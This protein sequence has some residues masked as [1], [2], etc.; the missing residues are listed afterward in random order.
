MKILFC[1]NNLSGL[2]SFR[3]P[4]IQYYRDK[5]C[6]VVLVVPKG[7][8][9][10]LSAVP[11]GVKCIQVDLDRTNTGLWNNVKLLFSLLK[12]Y[13][14]EKPDIIF[15]YTIKPNIFGTIASSIYSI[16]SIA[17]MAGLGV[18]FSKETLLYSIIRKVYKTALFGTKK[19]IV[20]NKANYDTLISLK[21]SNKDKLILV[22][23]E[24]VD[25]NYYHDT[26]NASDK[27]TFLFI[28]RILKEKGY[29]VFVDAAKRIK[30]K[31]PNVNFDIVG[32]FDKS[33]I[34]PITEEQVAKDENDG[35]INYRGCY[36]NMMDVYSQ[37][38]LVVT[39]PSYY[40]E[41]LNRSLMEACAC[42]KPVITTDVPG[43]KETVN[44]GVNGFLCEPNDVDSIVLAMEKYINLSDESKQQMSRESR[45][46]AE[47]YFDVRDTIKVYDTL[48]EEFV[49]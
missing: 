23:G 44:D 34:N 18:V 20:L 24:G 31:Y 33:Q 49:N 41:G 3:G 29:C 12:I 27:I 5:G 14:I 40:F 43:C 13:K 38:G 42:G 22:N 11:D 28:G 30:G 25:L 21:F 46:L 4:V 8:E 37:S 7:E 10:Y 1:N 2:L 47:K 35:Y 9:K 16:P 15:H 32:M 36:M 45:L 17:M 39:I 19:I 48:I 6:D 26:N